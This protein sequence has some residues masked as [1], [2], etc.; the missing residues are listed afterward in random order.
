MFFVKYLNNNA[1]FFRKS[2]KE[3]IFIIYLIV[4]SFL[5]LNE[6]SGKNLLDSTKSTATVEI[7]RNDINAIISNPDFSNAIIG[8]CVQ[9]NE[10]G[11]YF[12]TKNESINFIPASTQKVLTT[13]AALDYFGSD[14]KFTTKIYLD[15]KISEK[16]EFVGNVII[17]GMGDPTISKYFYKEP[18]EILDS[19]AR[20][21]DSMGISSIRGNLIADDSYFDDTH[22]GPG[23]SWDDFSYSYSPQISALSINDNRIDF[24]VYSGDSTGDLAKISSYPASNYYRVVNLIRT[25]SSKEEAAIFGV[26][27]FGTN[28]IKLYGTVPYDVT[29]KKLSN[30]SITIDNPSLFFLNLFKQSLEKQNIPFNG[31]LVRNDDLPLRINYQYLNPVIEHFS[32][33][34]IDIISLINQESHNLAAEVLLK[35]LGKENT[36]TGSFSTGAEYIMNFASKTGINNQNIKV[37]DGSGLSRLNLFSPRNQVT[38]LSYIFR[39]NMKENFVKTLAKPGEPGTLKRRMNRSKAEKSVT[40]KT[41]SMNNVSAICGYVT[42]RDS[43]T[44]SFSIMIQNFTT[45]L[46]MANNLQDLILMRLSSFSR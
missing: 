33:Q 44:L 34:L 28:I 32:P 2:Y 30:L 23:W 29:N 46:T 5:L 21:L 35:S 16:G 13:A 7:L 14:Y 31:G 1:N 22:Y 27:E 15:G 41:G 39:S 36:G 43:E 25:G 37:V 42:T 12:F 26:R 3:G 4:L 24:Y 38:L 11:E 8:I 9:S 10:T 45:Q 40:A 17:R 19:W 18:T 20:K 6:S